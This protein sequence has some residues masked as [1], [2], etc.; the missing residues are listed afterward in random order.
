[1]H[2]SQFAKGVI[3][4]YYTSI[5]IKSHKYVRRTVNLPLTGATVLD[6]GQ[7]YGGPYCAHL[8]GHLGAR[9]IKIEPPTRGEPLRGRGHQAGDSGPVNFQLLNGGK[10][11]VLLDL[12]TTSG[13]EAFLALC[14]T[15][16]VV[17][18]NFAPGTMDKLRIGYAEMTTVNPRIIHASLKAYSEDSPS[19]D[20]KGMDLTV[21]ASS[22][23]MAVNGFPEGPPVKCGPSLVDFLGGAHLALGILAAHIERTQTG[24]GQQ[25]LV[26]LQDSVIP[27]LAS[28]IASWLEDPEVLLRT[29]NH[30]GGMAECPYN[31]YPT[32][33]GH[34]AILCLTPN[35]WTS[36][37]VAMGR[38]DLGSD[39][40]LIS[41][42]ARS[43]RMVELDDA[44]AGWTSTLPGHDIEA[45]L[46]ECGVPAA[47]VR[48]LR[49]LLEGESG[50]SHPMFQT[51]NGPDGQPL[52]AFGSPVRLGHHAAAALRPSPALA[53]DNAAVLAGLD[54]SAHRRDCTC[55]EGGPR[56]R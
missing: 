44:V 55:Y 10:E 48:D 13:R 51:S 16:D 27:T 54:E 24:H 23:V 35:H 8:L 6:L 33:D 36:L 28:N 41:S 25:V 49:D 17:V 18:E 3:L 38:A 26:S 53:Q 47:R 30:H 40:S 32:S 46:Q 2:G 11:S 50:R 14:E 52:Y 34:I 12:K 43:A 9:V 15:S 29:G 5:W 22:G 42:Q 21:Q 4:T 37:C 45:L 20:L 39:L 31:S 56:G 19:R 7:V 1:M